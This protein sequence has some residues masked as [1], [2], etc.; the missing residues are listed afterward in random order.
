MNDRQSDTSEGKGVNDE[1]LIE[2]PTIVTRPYLPE[3]AKVVALIHNSL[4]SGGTYSAVQMRRLMSKLLTSGGHAWVS[5]LEEQP[6]AYATL[7]PVPGLDGLFDI[8]GGV[9]LTHRR[10]GI[11]SI[12]LTHALNDLRMSEVRQITCAVS[13]LDSAVAR[14]LSKHGFFIEHEE[15]IMVLDD[16]AQF[17]SA[18]LS[19]RY[20]LRTYR[21]SSAISLFRELYDSCFS[22]LAWYQ[23]YLSDKEVSVELEAGDDILFLFEGHS[24]IGFLW[25]RWPVVD[26]VKIEPVGIIVDRRGRGL[27][28]RLIQ[29]GLKT[30]GARGARRATLGVWRDN[31]G[32]VNLYKTLEFRHSGSLFYLAYNV[33]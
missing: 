5:T 32:A 24:P 25:L 27:G 22:G 17:E 11:G 23:P 29:C 8:G 26:T 21:R 28:N 19:T 16:L 9:A 13:T 1:G 31:V 6:I 14:F 30:A 33:S 4:I 7:A 10:S 12:L 3:D 2:I 18:S 20:Q 15:W